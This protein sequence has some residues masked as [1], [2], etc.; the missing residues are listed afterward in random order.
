MQPAPVSKPGIP[1]T[2]PRPYRVVYPTPVLVISTRPGSLKLLLPPKRLA[3]PLSIGSALK[4]AEELSVPSCC[5]WPSAIEKTVL[6][7][8]AA[9]VNQY[10]CF[11][12]DP[13]Y[14]SPN[15]M[16]SIWATYEP[17]PFMTWETSA[18]SPANQ[19]LAAG[20]RPLKRP[21]ARSSV[22][23]ATDVSSTTPRPSNVAAVICAW[24][25][26]FGAD[27]TGVTAFVDRADSRLELHAWRKSS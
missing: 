3:R 22:G 24:L 1:F 14:A 5:C 13:A 6:D 9:A 15:W 23:F 11:T 18:P 21:V 4:A 20:K 2:Q 12:G 7:P 19:R 16:L 27:L 25:M 10:T 26:A 17:A 8:L